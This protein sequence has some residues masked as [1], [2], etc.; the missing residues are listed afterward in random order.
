MTS[1]ALLPHTV[2]SREKYL[3]HIAIPLNYMADFS[4][5][6]LVVESYDKAREVIAQAGYPL[7]TLHDFSRIGLTS[8]AN[9]PHLGDIL[10]ANS[11]Y[12]EYSDIVETLYQA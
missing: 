9:I 4:K 6:G 11:I 8:P 2:E 3:A 1:I 5:M 12:W 7:Q 10:T